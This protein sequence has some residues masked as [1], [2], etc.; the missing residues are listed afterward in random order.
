MA[1]LL[2]CEDTTI[3]RKSVRVILAVYRNSVTNQLAVHIITLAMI[4]ARRNGPIERILWG[5]RVCCYLAKGIG[6]GGLVG[7]GVVLGAGWYSVDGP[8]S[9]GVA[10]RTDEVSFEVK[11]QRALVGILKPH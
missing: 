6:K 7:V 3:M 9:F 4:S 8:H 1:R 11:T 2:T 5:L 10:F